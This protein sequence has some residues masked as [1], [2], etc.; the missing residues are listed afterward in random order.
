[1]SQLPTPT[2]SIPTQ[3]DTQE[4]TGPV[5]KRR[6]KRAL[7]RRINEKAVEI[8]NNV[9]ENIA[10]GAEELDIPEAQ[11][12]QRFTVVAPVGEQ[13]VPMWW[14]GLVAECA[15]SWRSEYT[16]L[17]REFL[18]W[19]SKRIQDEGLNKDL[20]DKDKERYAKLA[21]DTRA[22]NKEAKMASITR[23]KAVSKAKDEVLA[24]HQQFERLN[25]QVGLEFAI[26]VTRGSVE[27][28]V[29]PFYTT[30]SKAA[31]FLQGHLNL[32][33][34]DVLTLMDLWAVG[35]VPGS[36][37]RFSVEEMGLK[38]V[39]TLLAVAGKVKGRKDMYQKAVRDKLSHSY[40]HILK[41]TGHDVSSFRHI[42]YSN[43]DKI[44]LE[45]KIVLQ[46]YLL[47]A[48]GNIVRKKWIYH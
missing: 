47:T 17:G 28:D 3:N 11:L 21:T 13:R 1:M 43:Y 27:D 25:R 19:V 16:G 45:Y 30:S 41:S 33:P 24:L 46:G 8:D 35:G 4:P 48:E 7:D 36:C 37:I 38:F 10:K 23:K 9:R 31:T 12:L 14:N 42:P 29:E 18:G 40:C 44:V 2:H 6:A 22:N 26:F 32:P 39:I 20:T 34:K 15:K 5:S